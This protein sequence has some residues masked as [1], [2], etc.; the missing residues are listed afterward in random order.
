MTSP[1]FRTS[2]RS[3]RLLLKTH[4][5]PYHLHSPNP[6]YVV[7]TH[8]TVSPTYTYLRNIPPPTHLPRPRLHRREQNTTNLPHCVT[9]VT[10]VS[11]SSNCANVAPA[12]AALCNLRPNLRSL[13][14]AAALHRDLPSLHGTYALHGTYSRPTRHLPKPTRT[15]RPVS[16]PSYVT[17]V[18]YYTN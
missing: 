8:V 17:Y 2:P 18:T 7:L 15:S 5:R 10:Y 16:T 6:P 9:Y 11:V 4:A 1:Y 14:N 13:C 3:P 12:Y